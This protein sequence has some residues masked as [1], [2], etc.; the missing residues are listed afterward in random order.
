MWPHRHTG[1]HV[2]LFRYHAPRPAQPVGFWIYRCAALRLWRLVRFAVTLKCM[3]AALNLAAEDDVPAVRLVGIVR[4]STNQFALIEAQAGPN[5]VQEFLF[6]AGERDGPIEVLAIDA[7]EG[8]VKINLDGQALELQFATN[9]PAGT[10]VRTSGNGERNRAPD[11]SAFIRLQDAGPVPVFTLYQRLVK[12]TLIRPGALPTFKLNL[13]SESD[14]ATE[15]L[16]PAI[17]RAL[18]ET[19]V[20]LRPDRDKFVI[21]G[22]AKDLM[23]VGSKEWQTAEE[24]GRTQGKPTTAVPP[25]PATQELFPAGTI[26]FPSTDVAQ[27]LDLYQAL[28]GRTVIREQTLPAYVIILQTQTPITQTDAIYALIAS[29]AINGA[30]VVPAD[31]KFL[32]VVATPHAERAT[33]LLDRKPVSPAVGA[34]SL[35]PGPRGQPFW[36]LDTVA[37][38]YQKLTGKTVE[39]AAGLPRLPFPPIRNQTPLT[40]SE[41]LRSLDLLLG[42]HG[43]QVVE[44]ADGKSLKIVAWPE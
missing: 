11:K 25:G 12:R 44:Q 37:Q 36:D 23:R 16:A 31:D 10:L 7:P 2:T 33:E 38:K 30:T 5:R 4:F 40:P 3:A 6:S 41:A 8:K 32:L 43:M 18:A 1:N 24:L 9:Q 19:R 27:V 29:L 21:A 20:L 34:E 15:D 42:L 35:P 39:V 14:I 13:Y 28:M 17:E 22:G 26:N